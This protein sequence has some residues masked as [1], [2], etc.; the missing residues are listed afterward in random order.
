MLE[1]NISLASN[2]NKELFVI[3]ES[4]GTYNVTTNTTGWGTPN[5]EL[6]DI[7]TSILNISNLTSGITYD[8][9][10]YVH[11]DISTYTSNIT[12]AGLEVSSTPI[13]TVIITDG[14]YCFEFNTTLNDATIISTTVKYL[15]LYSIECKI[16]KLGLEATTVDSSCCSDCLTEKLQNLAKAFT[17]H[18]LIRNAFQCGDTL[19]ANKLIKNLTLFLESLDCKNC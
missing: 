15:T 2:V 7:S 8:S 4:T 3:S 19:T 6:S 17:L 12:F 1:I 5:S 13:E 18:K 16:K 11:S 10:A 14:I 9:I